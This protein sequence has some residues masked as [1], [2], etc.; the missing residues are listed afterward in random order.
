MM[1]VLI[2]ESVAKNVE[3]YANCGSD[4]GPTSYFL[5]ISDDVTT[6]YETKCVFGV[7]GFSVR[8]ISQPESSH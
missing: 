8:K 4:G 1:N 5:S 7:A 2:N 3:I 6:K